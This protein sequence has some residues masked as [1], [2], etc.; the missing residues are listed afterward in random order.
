MARVD[1]EANTAEVINISSEPVKFELN[2]VRYKLAPKERLQ[3]H[4]NYALPRIMM[5]GRDPVPAAIELLT[6]G[7]VI[8]A[9]DKRAR[10]AQGASK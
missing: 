6:N 7:K 1:D 5:A 4:K 9:T 3:V 8:L 2:G 10:V